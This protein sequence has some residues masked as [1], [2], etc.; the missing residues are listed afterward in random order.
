MH[1]HSDTL[2]LEAIFESF[3]NKCLEIY[4]L[5]PA[6]FFSAPRLAWQACLKKTK[7]EVKLLTDADMLLM[8]EKGI[9]SR[10]RYAKHR[11]V[12]AS[13]NYTKDYDPSI[14]S[15]YL[16]YWDVNNLYGWAMP[17]KLPVDGSKWIKKKST[18]TPK[19]VRSYNDNS[20]NS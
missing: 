16:M 10:I 1:V 9:R 7:V 3:K 4:E 5:D 14:E 6:H 19:F 2:L 17:K 12:K 8:V 18:F 13:N 11:H 20:N 15:S